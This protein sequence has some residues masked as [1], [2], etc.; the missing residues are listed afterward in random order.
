VQAANVLP[1]VHD[2]S[3]TVGR[4]FKLQAALW[5]TEWLFASIYVSAELNILQ[6]SI[7]FALQQ[8]LSCQI[9]IQLNNFWFNCFR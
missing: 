6:G 7:D 5:Q 2:T 4:K 1:A 9:G 8:H 3:S